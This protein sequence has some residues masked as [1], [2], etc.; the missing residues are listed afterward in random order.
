MQHFFCSLSLDHNIREHKLGWSGHVSENLVKE[1]FHINIQVD[2]M[3]T[4]IVSGVNL[5]AIKEEKPAK[6]HSTINPF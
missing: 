5:A 4:S 6:M 1:L 2:P 3:R